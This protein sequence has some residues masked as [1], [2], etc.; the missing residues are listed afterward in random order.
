MFSLLSSF[1]CANVSVRPTDNS[2]V[3]L[4]SFLFFSFS[5]SLCLSVCLSVRRHKY[6]FLQKRND[7]K[8]KTSRKRENINEEKREKKRK[9]KKLDSS[10]YFSTDERDERTH[11]NARFFA[12]LRLFFITDEKIRIYLSEK[13][14]LFV[15]TKHQRK[16]KIP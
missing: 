3:F 7:E 6:T 11:I 9:E 2:N 5:L 10:C 1:S 15:L 4:L 14:K 8:K 12:L 16:R 13:K